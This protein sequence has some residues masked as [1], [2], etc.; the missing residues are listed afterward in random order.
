MIKFFRKIRR[1][2][3][4]E[5]KFTKYLIYAIGEIV[6]VVI[7]ILIA[8]QINN[9]NENRKNNTLERAFIKSLITDLNIDINRLNEVITY[10]EDKII[11]L[12]SLL[13][14][15]N[16]NI[17]NLPRHGELYRF[18]FRAFANVDAFVNQNRAFSY[19]ATLENG[20][21]RQNVTDSIISFQQKLIEINGQSNGYEKAV[22]DDPKS[23]RNKLFN[24]TVFCDST[25][26][27]KNYNYIGGGKP[28]PRIKDN[29]ALQF[30]FFNY[31][32]RARNVTKFYISD[33]F[34]KGHRQKTK[35]FIKFLETEYNL[36][37][38]KIL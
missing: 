13:T 17:N 35:D 26:F 12:D 23:S 16:R 28:F 2:L 7:G 21:V 15:S 9:W 34:L 11:T 19:F 6:L 27:D 22:L 3:L 5:N 8:L 10:N 25:Y 31:V 18:T 30:E 1:Q 4:T 38:D 24:S 37:N 14:Y 20:I 29:T 33:Y 36:T 32:F